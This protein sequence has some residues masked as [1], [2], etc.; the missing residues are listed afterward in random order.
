MQALE[1]YS[2]QQL[3]DCLSDANPNAWVLP[4][5]Q[6]AFV[7]RKNQITRLVDSLLK[8]FPV[9]SVLLSEAQGPHFELRAEG[10]RSA[11]T[12]P[13]KRVHLLDG[14]QRSLSLKASFGGHG[15]VDHNSGER[16]QLW[17]N[18]TE[19]YPDVLYDAFNPNHNDHGNRYHLRWFSKD[20]G[21]PN[22][23]NKSQR[24]KAG[25]RIAQPQTPKDGW[26]RVSDVV[27]DG[28]RNLDEWLAEACPKRRLSKAERVRSKSIFDRIHRAYLTGCIPIHAL[29]SGTNSAQELFQ[30]FIRL[31]SAGTPLGAAEQ[32]FAGVKQH[33][34]E[35]EERLAPLSRFSGPLER[36]DLI[37]LVA[38]AAAKVPLQRLGLPR[39][40]KAT[41][42]E[43]ITVADPIPVRLERLAK[44]PLVTHPQTGIRHNLLILKMDA[45]TRAD[46]P[47]SL[48]CAMQWVYEAFYERLHLGILGISSVSWSAAVAWVLGMWS[49]LGTRP[50]M[51]PEVV[52]PLLRFCFWTSAAGSRSEGRR[53]F[54]RNSFNQGWR[55]GLKGQP[56]PFM[57]ACTSDDDRLA[58][59]QMARLAFGYMRVIERLPTNIDERDT[60]HQLM[61][62]NKWLFLGSYQEIGAGWPSERL[63]DPRIEWDH[64]FARVRADRFLKRSYRTQGG[65]GRRQ[66]ARSKAHKWTNRIGN[67]AG[68]DTHAN[69]GLSDKS[70]FEKMAYNKKSVKGR[71]KTYQDR[72]YIQ[73]DPAL[74]RMSYELIFQLHKHEAAG[75]RD[76]GGDI[77]ERFARRRGDQI[78]QMVTERLGGPLTQEK[79]RELMGDSSL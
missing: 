35:A 45:V 63:L 62:N 48:D 40:S 33:W 59:E 10:V 23:W 74:D 42:D 55:F 47:L 70:I 2:V 22:E 49:R 71:E 57:R 24:V 73:T 69:R 26:V 5:S 50:E 53:K 58:C 43:E 15:F 13:R 7:W 6:R 77:F 56:F 14:Q 25:F 31:N 41:S 72:Q 18:L 64:I 20:A 9:G 76:A 38:R 19:P 27:K 37:T 16:Q 28:S 78:W 39:I 65:S 67:F 34:L 1:V 30:I 75:D 60:K 66:W 52:D 44:A 11:E 36:R 79:A 4:L 29:E 8:G 51:T 46:S 21:N 68:I 12:A 61:S 3:L 17:I 54:E 32:F